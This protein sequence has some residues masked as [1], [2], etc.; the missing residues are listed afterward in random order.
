[1]SSALVALDS[2]DSKSFEQDLIARIVVS[3][4]P[5]AVRQSDILFDS[6]DELDSH[7][8]KIGEDSGKEI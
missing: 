7:H 5:P 4:Q 3:E 6:V 1:M 2:A 8:L